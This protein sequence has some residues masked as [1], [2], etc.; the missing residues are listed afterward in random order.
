MRKLLTYPNCSKGGVTSVI[1]GRAA[2]EPETTFDVI[3]VNDRGGSRAFDDLQ[4]VNVRIIRHDRLTA[5]LLSLTKA[6]EYD[7][8]HVL[9]QPS[10]ANE[11]AS[12]E[13]LAVAYEFHSTNMAIVESEIAKLDLN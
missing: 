6:V 7:S 1:R 11:L 2:A 10:I 13:E 12:S 8:I 5:Y 9:S 4:N 3:F